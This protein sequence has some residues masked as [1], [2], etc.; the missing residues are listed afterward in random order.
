MAKSSTCARGMNGRRS[1]EFL[2]RLAGCSSN[3]GWLVGLIHPSRSDTGDRMS[4]VRRFESGR[5]P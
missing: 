4:L 2:F 3:L 5:D 1:T